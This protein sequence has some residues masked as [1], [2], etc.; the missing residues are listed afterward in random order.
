MKK[1]F[2]GTETFKFSPPAAA[3]HTTDFREGFW[4]KKHPFK[5]SWDIFRGRLSKSFL[6][7]FYMHTQIVFIFTT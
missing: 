4:R 6:P 3:A 2:L 1:H 5:T 7:K